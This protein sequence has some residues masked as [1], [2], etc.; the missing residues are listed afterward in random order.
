MIFYL[1]FLI[2][3]FLSLIEGEL[4]GISNFLFLGFCL[5]LAFYIYKQKSLIIDNN[6]KTIYLLFLGFLF[7][8]F[9]SLFFSPVSSR[10]LNNLILYLAYFIYFLAVQFLVKKTKLFDFKSLL[11]ASVFF[12][13]LV[14]CFLSFYLFF[15]HQKP[16]FS[17]MN[18]I[19]AHFG[20][21]HLVDFLI[22]AFPLNLGL[23]M[24]EKD[25]FKRVFY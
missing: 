8:S 11:V 22:F 10:V 2:L 1:F 23:L 9:L 4:L 15:T 5:P 20:H 21:N 18:L 6:K 17:T 25:K 19:Y 14:L 3:V 7:F 16:P 13:S 12:P 24:T